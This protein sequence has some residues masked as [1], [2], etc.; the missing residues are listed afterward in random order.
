MAIERDRV[1]LLSG[2][3]GG[4]TLGSPVAMLIPNRDWP[5]WERAMSP[6]APVDA[7]PLTRP[8]PGHA[9]LPGVLKYGRSDVRDILERASARE[10]AARVAVGSVAKA[11]AGA[12]G[13][14]VL[15]HVLGIGSVRAARSGRGIAALRRASEASPVRCADR[16][17]SRRMVAAIRRAAARRARVATTHQ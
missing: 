5:N 7:V 2:V 15:G 4:E 11:L 1:E 8:R 6:L 13:V 14:G 12:F 10:T 9:D 3:R 16:G 17:A